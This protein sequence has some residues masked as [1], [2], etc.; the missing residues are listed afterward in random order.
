MK[1]AWASLIAATLVLGAQGVTA[2]AQSAAAQAKTETFEVDYTN[3]GLAPSHWTIVLHPDGS[4]RFSSYGGS[5][6]ADGSDLKAP[7]VNR[8]IQVS[9]EFAARVFQT[10]Y[11][12]NLFNTECESHLKVAFQGTKVF[13]YTG[14]K[15]S[16]TC[17]FNYSKNKEIESLGNSLM[18]VEQTVMEGARLELLLKHDPL[19]LDREMRYLV[20]AAKDG[21]AQQLC[22]IKGILTQLAGDP[23]VLDR[24][25]Q[26][27][28]ELLAKSNS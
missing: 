21:R 19:G 6:G 28:D 1:L 20:Q 26:W 25:R 23:E 4:G 14:P 7:P 15:G 18:A 27:A 12:H 22:V 3:P 9:K 2:R 13:R 16:G 24:V 11:K 8:D 10:A 17:T 5:M